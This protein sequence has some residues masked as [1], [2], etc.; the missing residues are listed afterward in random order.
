VARRVCIRHRIWIDWITWSRTPN[1]DISALPDVVHAQR[2]LDRLIRRYPPAAI[3][4][5]LD[6]A[7]DVMRY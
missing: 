3:N 1:V 6:D 5:A 7:E 4:K 2:R